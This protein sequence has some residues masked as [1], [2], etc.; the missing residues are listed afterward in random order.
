MR[1]GWPVALTSEVFMALAG[2]SALTAPA[3]PVAAAGAGV[4]E[5]D[6]GLTVVTG[7]ARRAAAAQARDGVD[8]AKKDGVGGE[9]RCRAVELQDGD[10][11][12]VVLA[13]LAQTHVVIKGQDA[14]GRGGRQERPVKVQPLLQ[15]FR[16]KEPRYARHRCRKQ[17][18]EA[19][20]EDPRRPHVCV[21]LDVEEDD[22]VAGGG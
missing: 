9:E 13:G 14:L 18:R 15:L 5:V 11:A 1:K 8:R 22:T 17:G 6:L 21:R 2:V 4:A 19:N 16:R 12:H 7:E 10:A 20:I 3:S